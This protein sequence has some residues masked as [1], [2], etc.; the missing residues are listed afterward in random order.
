MPR[1][2]WPQC[3]T[4]LCRPVC[5]ALF[6]QGWQVHEEMQLPA[7]PGGQSNPV[8]DI[9]CERDGVVGVYEAKL[10][11]SATLIRQAHWWTDKANWVCILL[12]TPLKPATQ[13][14]WEKFMPLLQAL[15]IGMTQVLW[16]PP[17]EPVIEKTLGA[18]IHHD[19]RGG[20][21]LAEARHKAP[22]PQGNAVGAAAG[23]PGGARWS[24]YQ[25][26]LVRLRAFVADHPG[27]IL[28]DAVRGIDHHWATDQKAVQKLHR[29]AMEG[30]LAGIRTRRVAGLL[31]LHVPGSPTMKGTK[32]TKE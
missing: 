10:S 26:T 17:G 13:I 18:T 32:N 16:E 7:L 1:A 19:G 28:K 24:P 22:R 29:I 25:D 20:R 8:A 23:S 14:E 27:C 11:L 21:L 30:G 4:D 9:V 2:R 12:P 15:G 31:R 3:E 5:D 6:A